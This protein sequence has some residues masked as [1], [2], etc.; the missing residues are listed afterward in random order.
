MKK[1]GGSYI[2]IYIYIGIEM[3]ASRHER[4]VEM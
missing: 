3:S 2:Y 4:I 1:C